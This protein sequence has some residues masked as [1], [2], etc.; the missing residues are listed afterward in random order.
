MNN[1]TFQVSVPEYYDIVVPE[2]YRKR[3]EPPKP[4]VNGMEVEWDE[5]LE[6]HP[7]EKPESFIPS[8][9][10]KSEELNRSYARKSC[11]EIIDLIIN[12]VS[13][14]FIRFED[15]ALVIDI[16]DGYYDE[17]KSYIQLN[18]ELRRFVNNMAIARSK[19]LEAYN[20]V[21]RYRDNTNPFADKKPLSLIDILNRMR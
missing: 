8:P 3:M 15:I 17:I 21:T 16:F 5:Y 14:E 7:G 11:S 10:Y 18:D 20:D 4:V 2:Y 9:I 6:T 12:E 19:L 13:F 1:L